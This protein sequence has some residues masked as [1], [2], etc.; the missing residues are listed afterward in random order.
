MKRIRIFRNC[1]FTAECRPYR[2]IPQ[3]QLDPL[4]PARAVQRRVRHALLS[5]SFHVVFMNIVE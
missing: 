3:L 4:A 5:V 2:G 1:S